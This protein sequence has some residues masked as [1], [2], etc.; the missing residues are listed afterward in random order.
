MDRG[1][2]LRL[3]QVEQVGIAAEVPRVIGEALAA[4]LLLGE[5]APL[6]QNAPGPVEH[7]NALSE[8]LLQPVARIRH[9][10]LPDPREPTGARAL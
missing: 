2:D 10:V 3:R 7:G 5:A 1:D 8:D 4:E 6:Q 9:I